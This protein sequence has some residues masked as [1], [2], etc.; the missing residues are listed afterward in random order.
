MRIIPVM[1][2]IGGKVVHGVAG[3]RSR[4]RPIKSK[5]T[6]SVLPMEVASDLRKLFPFAEIYI[7]DLDAIDQ[8]GSNM[9]DVL[10]L[11]G[12]GYVVYLDAGIGGAGDVDSTMQRIDRIVVGTETLES[13]RELE[14]ICTLH[15][16]VVVSLDYKGDDLLARDRSLMGL[17][18]E[19]LVDSVC[20]AGVSEIIYL[21]LSRV[22]TDSGVKS[23]RTERVIAA[24]RV[25]VL[26]GGGVRD[27]SDIQR[28]GEMGAAGVMVATCIHSGRIG[29]ED[30]RRLSASEGKPN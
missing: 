17:G 21:D 18:P 5:V 6:D 9:A 26:V 14:V 16:C 20:R 19:K 22:G 10:A 2:L 1:D 3:I 13:L 11:R 15:P 27:T 25:P 12:L 23:S 8:R 28:L 29:E 24:S 30:L 7:A 4:Y